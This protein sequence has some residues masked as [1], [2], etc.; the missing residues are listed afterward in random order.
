MFTTM[1]YIRGVVENKFAAFDRKLW[2]RNYYEHVIRHENS[3]AKIREYIVANP[4]IWDE[5][6]EN[7]MHM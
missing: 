3:L 4:R 7:P 1:F 5:D 6:R 2:Q